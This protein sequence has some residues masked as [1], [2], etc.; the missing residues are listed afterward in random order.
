MP[1]VT[2]YA[3]TQVTSLYRN[4]TDETPKRRPMLVPILLELLHQCTAT[5]FFASMFFGGVMLMIL[6]HWIGGQSNDLFV[7]GSNFTFFGA[8]LT[9]VYICTVK[10]EDS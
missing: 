4:F 10:N 6:H 5:A 7:I 2:Y 3:Y 8:I 1:Y 9:G